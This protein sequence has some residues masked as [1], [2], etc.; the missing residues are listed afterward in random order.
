VLHPPVECAILKR[1][2]EHFKYL[3]QQIGEID[4]ELAL[5]LADDDAGQRLMGIPGIGPITA[6]VLASEIGG[7]QFRC[8]GDFAASLGLV[9]RQYSTGGKSNLLGVSRRGDSHIRS[10]LV[11]CARAYMRFLDRRTGPLAEWARVLASRRHSNVVACA[12]ANKLARIA[13]AIVARHTS[14]NAGPVA[15][16]A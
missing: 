5:K 11:Q 10:L 15:L 4:R 8:G 3:Q 6:S 1:L 2:H 9:P 14:F 7:T 16:P 13:W 12:V